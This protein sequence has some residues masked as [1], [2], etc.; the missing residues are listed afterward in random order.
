M[1]PG[2][3]FRQGNVYGVSNTAI[4]E[5]NRIKS[6]VNN[7]RTSVR[8]G[9]FDLG[10]GSL[11]S[12]GA[13]LL[14]GGGGTAAVVSQAGRPSAAVRNAAGTWRLPAPKNVGEVTIRSLNLDISPAAVY[15]ATVQ[16]KIKDRSTQTLPCAGEVTA[17]GDA[18]VFKPFDQAAGDGPHCITFT[19]TVTGDTMTLGYGEA[20][21]DLRR[22]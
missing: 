22:S 11:V 8:I 10:L 20:S 7:K 16:T 3:R 15:R 2:S 12:I 4:G 14:V 9:R 13:V 17:H 19:A 6:K 5:G 1:Q 18:L 21:A